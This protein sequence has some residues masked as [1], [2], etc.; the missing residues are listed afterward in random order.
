MGRLDAA[1]DK[2]KSRSDPACLGALVTFAWEADR[3]AFLAVGE[4]GGL[5]FRRARV[6]LA[7]AA[8]RGGRW[9]GLFVQ[10]PARLAKCAGERGWLSRGTWL[11]ACRMPWCGVRATEA[12]ASHRIVST[13]TTTTPSHLPPQSPRVPPRPYVRRVHVVPLRIHLGP[14][15]RAGERGMGLRHCHPS[16]CH[17]SHCHPSHCHLSPHPSFVCKKD[18]TSLSPPPAVHRRLVHVRCPEAQVPTDGG[19]G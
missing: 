7:P 6:R 8:R 10:G 14:R 19:D 3:D 18:L 5:A 13:A 12:P 11:V 1:I 16:H 9:L 4:R 17:L 2:L 15:L